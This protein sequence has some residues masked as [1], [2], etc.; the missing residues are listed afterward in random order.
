MS[1]RKTLFLYLFAISTCAPVSSIPVFT[2]AAPL[3]ST[4]ANVSS[5]NGAGV[6]GTVLLGGPSATDT[7]S[8]GSS[9]GTFQTIPYNKGYQLGCTGAFASV[10]AS[11]SEHHYPLPTITAD[12]ATHKV[13]FRLAPL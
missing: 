7:S 3:G 10:K 12:R 5:E 2:F 4:A 6:F 13:P 9:S 11:F 1:E 8:C